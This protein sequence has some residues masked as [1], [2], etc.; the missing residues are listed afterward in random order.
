MVGEGDLKREV[1]STAT[2]RIGSS[3]DLPFLREMLFEDAFWRPGAD[4]G[5]RLEKVVSQALVV[6]SVLAFDAYA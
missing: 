2:I 5:R 4:A 3:A 6:T 1:V